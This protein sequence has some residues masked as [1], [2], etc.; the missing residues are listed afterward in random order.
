MDPVREPGYDVGN[1]ENI[2]EQRPLPFLGSSTFRSTTDAQGAPHLDIAHYDVM[3]HGRINLGRSNLGMPLVTSGTDDTFSAQN[4]LFR[5][6]S[7]VPGVQGSFQDL[8]HSV[9]SRTTV[10]SILSTEGMHLLPEFSSRFYPS[11]TSQ[12]G[13]EGMANEHGANALDLTP[14]SP[15]RLDVDDSGY[16]SSDSSIYDVDSEDEN[17][18]NEA[19]GFQDVENIIEQTCPD[20]NNCNTSTQM[21]STTIEDDVGTSDNPVENCPCLNGNPF[22]HV[23]TE[24]REDTSDAVGWKKRN[25]TPK[26]QK[27]PDC[28]VPKGM[29]PIEI[30]LRNAANRKTKYIFE[31]LL[32]ITFDSENEGYD[33]YN[34]YS[35]EVGF[36][37]KKDSLVRNRKDYQTM[38]EFRC[39][40]SGNDD[41]CKYKTKKTGCKAMLRLLRSAD[42]GWYISCHRAEHNHP[43][44]ESCGEKQ[45]W[46]SHG[47]IDQCTKDMIKYLRENNVSLTKVHCIMGDMF[48]SMHNIPITKRSLRS[49]CH[50]IAKDQMNDD[51]QKT[52]N[53]FRQIRSEDPGFV[54][55]VDLDDDKRIKTLLWINGKSRDQ[56]KYFGDVITFDTTYC[57]NIY[58]M[59]FGLFVGVN[60]HFQST[61]FGGVF[62]KDETIP[63]FKW[64]FS[65]FLSL[66]GGKVPQT[67]FTDQCKA[68]AV[69]LLEEWKGAMH[70]WC[71]WHVFKDAKSKLGPIYKKGSP[72]RKEFHK[73]I[74]DMLTIEEFETAWDLMLERYDLRDNEYLVNIYRKRGKWAKA[75]FKDSFCA[76]M[77]STQRSES[78][79]HMLKRFVPRNCSMNRFILQFNKLL[80]ARNR[81]EDRAEFDTKIVNNVR[82]RVWPIEEHAMTL[83]TSAAYGLFQKEVDKST[84][85]FA[86]EKIKNKEF[87]VVHVKPHRKLPWAREKFTV[88]VNN[89]GESYECECGLYQ[90]FGMLCSHV[91]R[92]LVQ[93]GVYEVPKAHILKRWTRKARDLLPR[94]LRCYQQDTLCLQ[95]MTYRHTFLYINAM[96]IVQDGNK[97]LIAFD[98]VAKSLKKTQKKLREYYKTKE[99]LTQA[100]VPIDSNGFV[101]QNNYHTTDSDTEI[102]SGSE[103]EVRYY[104]SYG[105]AGSSAGMSDSELLKIRAPAFK[106]PAGRPRQNRFK[107]A[108]DIYAKKHKRKKSDF[109]ISTDSL[110]TNKQ[111]SKK[112]AKI[113]C[114]ECG[115]L[116]HNATSC[117]KKHIDLN[118]EIPEF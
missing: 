85:Y 66:M 113:R 46:Y 37:I 45:Q 42:D 70:L 76:R 98:I 87:D 94:E 40:C 39:L 58:K 55:V 9:S 34:M 97:D 104:N 107:S 17:D 57:T 100:G 16:A 106:R 26:G 50:Q 91:L 7:G 30:A 96:E 65:E 75:F 24:V 3:R 61:I 29:G 15:C 90:H 114:S 56:Y 6:A 41:R 23:M 33:F 4:M 63:S 11:S 18:A 99:S 89:E 43:L 25:I 117:K 59:P 79:N 44:T 35:W 78:A 118:T 8:L 21:T 14:N 101:V 49:I 48:G 83:Y 112:K 81:A 38:R 72:F 64:V 111:T 69:A 110:I 109:G 93:L 51:V 54:F 36:G 95:S 62:M 1:V 22:M 47:K 86:I 2:G 80:F 20:D 27:R 73:I 13:N 32:G 10:E 102:D 68:M 60:N 19:F 84:D 115:I 92:V 5:Q 103:T 53:I 71:K 77:S 12:P 74:N 28:R 67:V 108:I 82:R 88:L 31:P 105:A 116:G 52:L